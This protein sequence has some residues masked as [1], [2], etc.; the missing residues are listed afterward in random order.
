MT[1]YLDVNEITLTNMA[2][3][4]PNTTDP[5]LSTPKEMILSC[6]WS[7][8]IMSRWTEDNMTQYLRAL[9]KNKVNIT[10][11]RKARLKAIRRKLHKKESAR[12]RKFK[13]DQ[14]QLRRNKIE[15]EKM[16]T[17]LRCLR[18]VVSIWKM[19]NTCIRC[20][21]HLDSSDLM[22]HELVITM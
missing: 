13:D 16:S 15:I 12:R 10:S 21:Q 9:R 8:G 17:E 1:H 6:E 19:G 14:D 18:D 4:L 5:W 22:C 11:N 20:N 2:D 3:L 7:E